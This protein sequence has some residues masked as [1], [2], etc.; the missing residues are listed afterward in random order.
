MPHESPKLTD[1]NHDCGVVS[2]GLVLRGV[3][4]DP[5]V[6]PEVNL[7]AL[8]DILQLIAPERLEHLRKPRTG[9]GRY[10][11]YLMA[12]VQL[13]KGSECSDLICTQMNWRTKALIFLNSY[14]SRRMANQY[15]RERNP[16]HNLQYI[17]KG[18]HGGLEFPFLRMSW[19]IS[20]GDQAPLILEAT[21][22]TYSCPRWGYIEKTGVFPKHEAQT[23]P[24][25]TPGAAQRVQQR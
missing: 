1:T 5:V 25:E 24:D 22:G 19:Y 10:S 16:Q 11:V 23:I 8:T 7:A 9:Q 12:V 18:A 13:C 21:A 3:A 6:C 17:Q 14:R 2:V 15:M 4:L 20:S